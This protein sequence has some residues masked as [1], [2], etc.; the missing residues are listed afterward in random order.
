MRSGVT[1]EAAPL[2]PCKAPVFKLDFTS[3]MWGALD[4]ACKRCG[5]NIRTEVIINGS[6]DSGPYDLKVTMQV[7]TANN[8]TFKT[9]WGIAATDRLPVEFHSD[10]NAKLELKFRGDTTPL[11]EKL[12]A[13]QRK[14]LPYFFIGFR[15]ASGRGQLTTIPPTRKRTRLATKEALASYD[16]FYRLVPSSDDGFK[17]VREGA[18]EGV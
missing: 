14:V 11:K 13:A 17:L 15:P 1:I 6:Q 18:C 12:L 16:D 5:I 3:I 2:S 7:E 8:P 4:K 9:P 10:A